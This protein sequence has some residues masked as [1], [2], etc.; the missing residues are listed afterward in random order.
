MLAKAQ[1]IDDHAEINEEIEQIINVHSVANIP[2]EFKK[3]FASISGFNEEIELS[4]EQFYG[5]AHIRLDLM[6]LS[7]K[8]TLTK[9]ASSAA[10]A[11]SS[12]A[13][14]ILRLNSSNSLTPSNS[15]LSA[16]VKYITKHKNPELK[17]RIYM[18]TYY[19]LYF[20]FN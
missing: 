3:Y 18:V 10:M 17:V 12:S 4:R 9:S 6:K 2:E 19:Q 8:P 14:K 15:E 20:I 11:V 5:P 16:I 13:K 7:S 1:T